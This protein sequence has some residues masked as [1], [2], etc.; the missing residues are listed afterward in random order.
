ME[1]R[2]QILAQQAKQ[3]DKEAFGAL[4]TLYYRELYAYALF[5]L[6]NETLAQD[7]VQEATLAAYRSIGSLRDTAAFKQW[8]LRILANTCR[9]GLREKIRSR[10]EAN[11]QETGD[12]PDG[13][14]DF[15][16][17]AELRQALDALEPQEREILLLRVFGGY[18]SHE[19][20]SVL[21]CPAATVR[22]KQ[23]RALAKLH[24]I[25]TD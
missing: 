1:L 21:G 11:T 8:L 4:Y 22:S 14:M 15:I 19:I 23:K 24:D 9:G 25:L 12:L 7:A 18:K 16:L 3:G 17:C 10:E 6:G 5:V 13:E 20:A 2:P